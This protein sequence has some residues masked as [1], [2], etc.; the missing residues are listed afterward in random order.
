MFSIAPSEHIEVSRL[1]KDI[2][3]LGKLYYLGYHDGRKAIPA[4]KEYLG[5]E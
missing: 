5:I 3:K 2:E 4:L 1:E